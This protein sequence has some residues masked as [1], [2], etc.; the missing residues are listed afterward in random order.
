MLRDWTRD[1]FLIGSTLYH[2]TTPGVFCHEEKEK[3]LHLVFIY[4]FIE[5]SVLFCIKY[6]V[7]KQACEVKGFILFIVYSF[8]Q[9]LLW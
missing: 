5:P 2:W 4:L 3:Q 9:A 6:F 7:T 1:L 8:F